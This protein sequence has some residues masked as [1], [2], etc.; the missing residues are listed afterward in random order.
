MPSSGLL[1]LRLND[2]GSLSAKLFVGTHFGENNPGLL[3]GRLQVVRAPLRYGIVNR[4]GAVTAL[5]KIESARVQP[6]I[7]VDSDHVTPIACFP[8]ERNL[9]KWVISVRALGRTTSVDQFPFPLEKT[10]E[11]L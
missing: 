10:R 9:P 3:C 8:E 6:G 4:F 11:A 2:T 1:A 5:Q 7:N